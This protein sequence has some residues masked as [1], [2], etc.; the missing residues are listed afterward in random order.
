ME[1]RVAAEVL[2]AARDF[3]NTYEDARRLERTALP[4]V[5][6]KRDRVWRKYRSGEIGTEAFLAVQRDSTTLVRYF[7]DTL[8][9]ATGAML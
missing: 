3:E 9:R 2:Q 4:A 5:R 8:A 6:R 7:R 1:R